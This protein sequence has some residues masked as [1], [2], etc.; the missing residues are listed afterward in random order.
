MA[1]GCCQSPPQHS[2]W[3]VCRAKNPDR[4][5]RRGMSRALRIPGISN[6]IGIEKRIG[7]G[8]ESI[9]Q[10]YFMFTYN[11][12]EN[13]KNVFDSYLVLFYEIVILHIFLCTAAVSVPVSGRPAS[14]CGC[15]F[16]PP[17]A[18]CKMA[19]NRMFLKI[20]ISCH[21][22]MTAYE[23]CMAIHGKNKCVSRTRE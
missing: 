20:D 13:Y 23:K 4:N 8:M 19:E 14:L 6:G 2:S 7:R 15:A 9:L 5:G 11:I 10:A 22:P 18:C 17:V 3:S 16:A 21:I 12:F 1:A